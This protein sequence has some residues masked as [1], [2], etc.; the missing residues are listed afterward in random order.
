MK[1]RGN[2]NLSAENNLGASFRGEEFAVRT[3]KKVI[4]C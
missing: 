2:M 1:K 3:Q 4:L